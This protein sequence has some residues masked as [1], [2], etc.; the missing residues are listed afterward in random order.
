MIKQRY[1]LNNNKNAVIYARYSSSS[2]TEQS[3]EGQLHKCHDFAQHNGYTV[4]NEYIDRGKTGTN[5]NRPA[6]Q[7]MV[8]DSE[9]GLFSAIIVYMVDRFAR[10]KED[11]VLYKALLRRNGVKVLYA[12][13]QIGDTDEGYLIEGLLE[14]F[15][16]Q[17][18]TKL[19]K[20]VKHGLIETRAKGNFTGG[21]LLIGHK[22][23]DH[24]IIIDEERAPII[25]YVFEQYADG[26]PIKKIIEEMN[27]RGWRTNKGNKFTINSLQ[28]A[29]RNKKYIGEYYFDGEKVS[30]YPA[31][32]DKELFN[33]VQ[34]RLDQNKRAPATQKAKVEYLLYGK[35][36]C[37]YCFSNMVGVSGRGRNGEKH[38]YYTCATKYKQHTCN[39]KTEQKEALE[40]NIVSYVK[41]YISDQ[42][43]AYHLA[44]M[45]LQE[46]KRYITSTRVSDVERLLKEI[47]KQLDDIVD[48][49]LSAK[50]ALLIQK[51]DEKA[52]DLEQQK[53]VLDKEL[54]KLKLALALPHSRDDIVNYLQ[55][56]ADGDPNDIEYRRKIINRLLKAVYIYDNQFLVYLNI[57]DGQNIAFDKLPDLS[58]AVKSTQ[59]QNFKGN[60]DN[61]A[62]RIL[63]TSLCHY[64]R[65][66]T[67]S[68]LFLRELRAIE[69]VTLAQG[70]SACSLPQCFAPYKSLTL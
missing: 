42:E 60:F 13:E 25:R 9:K 48:T 51:L 55:M 69:I 46:Y 29:L 20:R 19:S 14:M 6:F 23:I 4:I 5:A 41:N 67:V 7:N 24:K 36:F 44:D 61:G 21:N 33:R 70:A 37:G 16:E 28:N 56:F 26:V 18:S 68:F 2:Q 50:N 58:K 34:N 64:K 3:I 12:E 32:I 31:I 10:S 45:V 22:V 53:K 65:T 35:A 43:N 30:G 57:I 47:D 62:V 59:N 52:N 40:V 17:Y 8:N 39:K 66:Q 27:K 54:S 49:L 38:Y 1:E 63:S 15:A 11:S